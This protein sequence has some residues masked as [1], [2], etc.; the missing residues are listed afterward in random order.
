MIN[1]YDVMM[2]LRKSFYYWKSVYELQELKRTRGSSYSYEDRF[3]SDAALAMMLYSRQIMLDL[4]ELEVEKENDIMTIYCDNRVDKDGKPYK[5]FFTY[6]KVI[7]E[8][9]ENKGWQF[10]SLTVKFDKN[11]VD[12]DNLDN[13]YL[14]YQIDECT[15]PKYYKIKEENGIKKYPYIWIPRVLNFYKKEQN[16]EKNI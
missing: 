6:R 1:E 3:S 2:Y 7:V 16:Y 5:V 4:K 10:K 11:N 8:G 14:V 15:I 9:E 13:G 12:T